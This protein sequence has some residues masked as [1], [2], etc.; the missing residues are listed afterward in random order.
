MASVHP[1]F[2][3]KEKELVFQVN[4]TNRVFYLA[5]DTETTF[6]YWITGIVGFIKRAGTAD[7]L[8]IK[9]LEDRAMGMFGHGDRG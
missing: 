4:T 7:R 8:I 9:Q 1:T 2:D 3:F 6:N 5:A